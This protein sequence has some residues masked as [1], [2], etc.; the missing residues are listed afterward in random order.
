MNKIFFNLNQ[1]AM[2]K[3]T[4]S[5][6]LVAGAM[7]LSLGASAQVVDTDYSEYDNNTTVP[8]NIDYV[9]VG[10]TMGYYAL[11]DPVYHPDYNAAGSWALTAGFTWDWS[12]PTNPGTAATV[13]YPVASKPA[14]YVEIN[15]PVVGNYIVNV[16][17]HAPAAMGD[18]SDG[19]PTVM[20][21]TVI[22]PP[23]GDI[24]INPVPV[25]D[26]KVINANLDYQI[27]SAQAAQTVTVSFN[28]AVPNTLAA[29]SFAIAY[30]V[31][32][33]DGA[34]TVTS[35]PTDWTILED[36]TSGSKLKTA[37]VGTLPAAAFATATPA[38]T[39]TFNTP[40]LAI[41]QNGGVDARTR[42][43]YRLV[44]TGTLAAG[45]AAATNDFRSAISEKSDYLGTANY[46]NFTNSEVSFMVNPT[47]STG[48]IYHIAN[49]F[50]Y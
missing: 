24:S 40:A 20:N 26:W 36:F 11:P 14:N 10:A 3:S 7:I 8:T 12:V 17:E 4:F 34:G 30:K 27:C 5:A 28:E 43:T 21:V 47:P 18:C 1:H 46:I 48:P 50:A 42:Y 33:L 39:F 22:N 41:V 13:T 19:T 37:N 49:N 31:E 23:T 44:R 9:T 2:K 32:T 6:L 15:Y 16:A 45:V 35:T 25:A 29:Y 38:F